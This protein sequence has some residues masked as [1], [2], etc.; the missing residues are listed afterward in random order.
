MGFL[1]Q[2]S[3]RSGEFFCIYFSNFKNSTGKSFENNRK[4][5]EIL[6]NRLKTT[7]KSVKHEIFEAFFNDFWDFG[8]KNSIF[9]CQITFARFWVETRSDTR[10]KALTET[11][12]LAPTASS[13]DNTCE[14]YGRL[15]CFKFS[16]R[17]P[18]ANRMRPAISQP[19]RQRANVLNR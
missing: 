10:S 17:S 11:R 1:K 14:S 4:I 6:Q 5:S 12:R 16:A 13:Y 15:M 9:G 19:T 2:F 8:I 7:G 3:P 18:E